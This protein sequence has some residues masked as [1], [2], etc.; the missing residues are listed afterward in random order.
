M[1]SP[2]K[3]RPWSTYRN[4][5]YQDGVINDITAPPPCRD[6]PLR[7]QNK[8]KKKIPRKRPNQ[9]LVI[10][11]KVTP[12]GAAEIEVNQNKWDDPDVWGTLLS[13]VAVTIAETY[14]AENESKKFITVLE[15]SFSRDIRD[16]IKTR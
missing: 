4:K 12:E 6:H 1:N 2:T 7:W 16:A 11:V 14:A 5:T 10:R 9:D 15:Q 13:D 8:M 3:A